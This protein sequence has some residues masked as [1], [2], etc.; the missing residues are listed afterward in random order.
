MRR[1]L[2]RYMALGKMDC[3]IDT[4]VVFEGDTRV[5][6]DIKIL[7]YNGYGEDRFGNN[8]MLPTELSYLSH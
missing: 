3:S 6:S 5:L 1:A 7:A 8:I 4:M 2:T